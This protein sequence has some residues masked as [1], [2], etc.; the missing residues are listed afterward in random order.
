MRAEGL[1]FT[2]LDFPNTNGVCAHYF[3]VRAVARWKA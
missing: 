3:G 1:V 2:S